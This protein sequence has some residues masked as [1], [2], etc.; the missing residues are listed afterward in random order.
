MSMNPAKG[1]LSPYDNFSCVLSVD[2]SL[3]N[4]EANPVEGSLVGRLVEETKVD[5]LIEFFNKALSP[6][7]HSDAKAQTEMRRTL[8]IVLVDSNSAQKVKIAKALSKL[9]SHRD[10]DQS[11]HIYI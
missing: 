8:S 6:I 5:S 1:A 4:I 9:F 10:L 3:D 7:W 11:S 2:W